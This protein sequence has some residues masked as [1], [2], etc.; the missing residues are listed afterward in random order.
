M[1]KIFQN[2]QTTLYDHKYQHSLCIASLFTQA[3]STQFCSY[4]NFYSPENLSPNTQWALSLLHTYNLCIFLVSA[5]S[6]ILSMCPNHLKHILTFTS[7]FLHIEHPYPFS[8]YSDKYPRLRTTWHQW[9]HHAFH[10]PLI[11]LIILDS[12]YSFSIQSYRF[13]S[14]WAATYYHLTIPHIFL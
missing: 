7:K 6:F 9:G 3:L 13:L 1:P 8:F 10:R 11:S 2:I 14:L 5:P 4:L 12:P